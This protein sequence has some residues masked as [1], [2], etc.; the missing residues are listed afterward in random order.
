LVDSAHSLPADWRTDR[1]D[2]TASV[3]P[4]IGRRWRP[5]STRT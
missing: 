5:R 4:T 2:R 1:R 3:R